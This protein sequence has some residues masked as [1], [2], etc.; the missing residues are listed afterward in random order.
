M[1][2]LMSVMRHLSGRVWLCPADPDPAN[3][4]ASVAVIADEAGS[5]VVDAGNSP[6]LARRVQ[7][8]MVRA[9]LPAARRL[10]Y[11]HHHWDH[12]WGAC[13]WPDVEIIGHEA[14]HELMTAEA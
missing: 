13:A 11:T 8:A 9:G 12:T 14:G 10:I 7:A 2:C 4:Q 3:I 5:V 1:V 6:G